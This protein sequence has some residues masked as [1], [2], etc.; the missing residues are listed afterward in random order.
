MAFESPSVKDHFDKLSKRWERLYEPGALQA[1]RVRQFTETLAARR[2]APARVLD[3]GCGTGDISVALAA[4]GYSVTGV[5]MSNAMIERARA[6]NSPNLQ[7]QAIDV[8]KPF[9]LPFEAGSFD[10]V[11]SSS[12]FEYLSPLEE[13][14]GELRRV[15][16]PGGLLLCTVPNMAHRTNEK[17]LRPLAKVLNRFHLARLHGFFEWFEYMELSIHRFPLEQWKKKLAE[18]GWSCEA[19]DGEASTLWLIAASARPR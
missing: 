8:S 11:V 5:D 17:I 10:A 14:L 7:F 1:P 9:R 3:F 16:R 18:A 12:V 6:R 13:Y 2:A 19:A 4:A 15:T